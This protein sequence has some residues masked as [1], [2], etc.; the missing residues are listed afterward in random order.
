MQTVK[1][2]EEINAFSGIPWEGL[3]GR[4]GF[5]F[6]VGLIQSNNA[7]VEVDCIPVFIGLIEVAFA[8]FR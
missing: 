4:K 3:R 2:V 8:I 1:S 7:Y 6:C 5:P